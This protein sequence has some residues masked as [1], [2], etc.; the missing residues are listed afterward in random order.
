V[1]D[2]EGYHLPRVPLVPPGFLLVMSQGIGNFGLMGA[3]IVNT[4]RLKGLSLKPNLHMYVHYY[5]KYC[6]IVSIVA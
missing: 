6:S 4:E 1:C 2:I 3:V 5:H